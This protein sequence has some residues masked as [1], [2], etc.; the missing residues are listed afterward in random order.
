[1]LLSWL[2]LIVLAFVSSEPPSAAIQSD[3]SP[4]GMVAFFSANQCPAGWSSAQ[5]AQARLVLGV[6]TPSSVG[7]QVGDSVVGLVHGHGYSTQ[8][9]IPGRH[10]RA[11]HGSNHDGAHNGTYTVPDGGAGAIDDTAAA[12]PFVMLTVCQKQ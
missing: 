12:V 6:T 1:M 9:T 11:A 2:G 10:V 4:S 5:N 8:V 3:Q 7:V